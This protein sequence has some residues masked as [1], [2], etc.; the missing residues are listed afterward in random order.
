I[1]RT[2]KQGLKII[3]DIVP[4]HI[5]R[6]YEGKTNP[7]GVNDFGSN[8]D[9][10]VEYKRDNNFYYIPGTRFEVPTDPN[11]KPLGGE[12]HP[13]SDGKFEEVP[14]KWTGNG[15]RAPKP[16]IN[17]WYETVKI[18]YGI[19]PDGSKDFPLLPE[20]YDQQDFKAHAAF[21]KGKDVP[22]SWKKF[23]DITH[24]WIDKGIDGF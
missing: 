2:H 1:A 10:S 12:K 17:D 16:D 13:L 3:I 20:G 15:S 19:K 22:D 24:Y 5:A 8:D 7:A 14:A 23:R 21:W 4:N 9:T 6:R 18:N 11:Y